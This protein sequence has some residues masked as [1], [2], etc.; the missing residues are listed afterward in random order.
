MVIRSE[1]L[2]D[3]IAEMLTHN[4]P[5]LL[6]P[7][8]P[9]MRTATQWFPASNAQMIDCQNAVSWKSN[10]TDLLQQLWC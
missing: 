9:R 4:G 8:S 2:E 5:W 1:Q 7:T 3:A 10:R 6:M